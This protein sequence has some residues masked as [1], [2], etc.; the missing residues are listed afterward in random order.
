MVPRSCSQPPRPQLLGGALRL[1]LYYIGLSLSTCAIIIDLRKSRSRIL[2][3]RILRFSGFARER[4]E[5]CVSRASRLGGSNLVESHLSALRPFS[6]TFCATS[7]CHVAPHA[8]A[9]KIRAAL[10]PYPPPPYFHSCYL[11]P[12]PITTSHDHLLCAATITLIFSH[13]LFSNS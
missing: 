3:L 8:L 7:T 11:L 13:D 10:R 9:L 2:I 12:F 6:A 5:R 4:P 1:R